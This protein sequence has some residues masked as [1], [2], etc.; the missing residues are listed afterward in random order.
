M[1][2]HDAAVTALPNHWCASSCAMRRCA[3]QPRFAKFEP[4]VD[5]V[6]DSR[7]I[8]SGSSVMTAVYEAKGY[9]PKREEK[10]SIMCSWS[11]NASRTGSRRRG[12]NTRRTSVGFAWI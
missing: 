5:N 10:K 1:S 11:E 7:G 8:S 4:N 9:A 2:S 3:S 12:G 6:C